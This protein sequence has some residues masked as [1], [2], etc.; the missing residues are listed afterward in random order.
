MSYM[1]LMKDPV[2][3]P[4]WNFGKE[5]LETRWATFSKASATFKEQTLASLLSSETSPSTGKSHMEKLCVTI[6]LTKKRKEWV[7]L[8]VGGH[9]LDYSGEVETSTADI[10]TFKILID[11]TLYT[12]DAEII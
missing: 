3:K 8:A 12:K 4:L 7:R 10:T 6:N 1:A 5:G 2:L 9:R 11:G